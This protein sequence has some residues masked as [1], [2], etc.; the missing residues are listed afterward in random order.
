L[1]AFFINGKDEWV[2]VWLEK[3]QLEALT[4]AIEQFPFK[5]RTTPETMLLAFV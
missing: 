1:Q 3:E 5:S 2:R 4:T